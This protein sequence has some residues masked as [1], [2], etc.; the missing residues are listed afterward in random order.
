MDD[1]N[2]I[3]VTKVSLDGDQNQT[4]AIIQMNNIHFHV[5]FWER[6]IK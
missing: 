2:V 6:K 4:D 3:Y 5:I 1:L